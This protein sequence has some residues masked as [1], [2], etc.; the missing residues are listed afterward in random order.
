[1]VCQA[2]EKAG[3]ALLYSSNFSLGVNLFFALNQT[4]A[5]LMAPYPQYRAE[6]EE[7]TTEAEG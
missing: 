7:A 4:L 2:V 3:S 6:I 5:R 1:M